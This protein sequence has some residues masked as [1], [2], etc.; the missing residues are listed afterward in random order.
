MDDSTN[1]VRTMWINQDAYNFHIA[2]TTLVAYGPTKN[3]SFPIP[4]ELQGK[5]LRYKVVVRRFRVLQ[6]GDLAAQMTLQGREGM[7]SCRCIKC[8][9]TQKE[10]KTKKK[11][12]R[13]ITIEQLTAT[14]LETVRLGQKQNMLWTIC[15]TNTVVPI[16][17]CEIGAVNDQLF[18]KLFRQILSIECGSQEELDKQTRI[19]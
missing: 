17:H 16:L 6:V 4:P 1:S 11:D 7:A 14:N 12:G 15:P 8:D 9:L 19:L 18:K 3:Q 10:W 2:S 13:L 5:T